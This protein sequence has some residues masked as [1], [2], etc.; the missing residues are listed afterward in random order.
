MG[1]RPIAVVDA[2]WSAGAGSAAPLL[3]GLADAGHA[4]TQP[5]LL[6]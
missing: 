6:S 4:Q 3:E 1:G 5:A 2:L